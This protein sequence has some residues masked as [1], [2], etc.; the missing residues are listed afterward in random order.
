MSRIL[1]SA[2]LVGTTVLVAPAYAAEVTCDCAA[3]LPL[4]PS[5]TLGAPFKVSPWTGPYVGV[6]FALINNSVHQSENGPGNWP[7]A[8]GQ[9]YADNYS[10]TAGRVGFH[11]GYMAQRGAAVFGVET[12]V[13]KLLGSESHVGQVPGADRFRP[14]WD[15]SARLRAGV[16]TGNTLLYGTGGISFAKV[17]LKLDDLSAGSNTHVGWTA[18][19]GADVLLTEKLIGRIETRYTDYGD[20]NY[21]T[22]YGPIRM[23]YDEKRVALGLSYKF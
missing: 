16:V 15:A 13:G 20:E 4:P 6:T 8:Y 5:N 19:V 23:G 17:N 11:A 22:T 18:G 10:A 7:A 3:P 9:R 21:Q 2:T 1:L 14:S 12:D